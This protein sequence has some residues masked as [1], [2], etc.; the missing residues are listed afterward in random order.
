VPLTCA[1]TGPGHFASHY[2]GRSH[3]VPAPRAGSIAVSATVT[4]LR[5][6]ARQGR[7]PTDAVVHAMLNADLS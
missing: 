3:R 4:A 6:A 1:I 5:D 7:H 2:A